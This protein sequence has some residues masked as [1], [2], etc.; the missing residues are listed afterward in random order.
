MTERKDADVSLYVL[1]HKADRMDKEHIASICMKAGMALGEQIRFGAPKTVHWHRSW[2]DNGMRVVVVQLL[3]AKMRRVVSQAYYDSP[4]ALYF[5]Y[6][7]EDIGCMLGPST[8]IQ[9][10]FT[11]VE[12]ELR[13]E[14]LAHK[15]YTAIRRR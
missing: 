1:L 2:R 5:I 3:P 10:V 14:R 13:K 4:H 9:S 7:M 15:I 6:P 11:K 12:E 8:V